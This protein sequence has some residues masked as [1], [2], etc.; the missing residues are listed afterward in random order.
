MVMHHPLM[1]FMDLE[2][3]ANNNTSYLKSPRDIDPEAHPDPSKL[4]PKEFLGN[5]VYEELISINV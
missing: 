2:L 4:D 3:H 5:L 1:S